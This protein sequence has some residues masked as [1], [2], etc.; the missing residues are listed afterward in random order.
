MV[1][2]IANARKLEW[3]AVDEGKGSRIGPV[4]F[5]GIRAGN[6]L[7]RTFLDVRYITTVG[8][9]MYT[10][11]E[12]CPPAI[13]ACFCTSSSWRDPPRLAF[14]LSEKCGRRDRG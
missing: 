3:D 8:A 5:I 13:C 11:A 2:G 10:I 1:D 9:R 12:C 14:L 6:K 7:D 4:T